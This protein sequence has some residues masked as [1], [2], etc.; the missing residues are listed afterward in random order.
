MVEIAR[1]I[2]G[3]AMLNLV[4]R[5]RETIPHRL[6][7]AVL[8]PATLNLV[9]RASRPPQKSLRKSNRRHSAVCYHSN[10]KFATVSNFAQRPNSL[11]LTGRGRREAAGGGPKFPNSA[12][13]VF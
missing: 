9:R 6:A 10:I 5:V 4:W 3:V 7:L 12:F 11:S 13:F 8:V 2:A 1:D